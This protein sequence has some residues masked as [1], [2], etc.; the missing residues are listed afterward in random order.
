MER[1]SNLLDF[2]HLENKMELVFESKQF[3][4]RVLPLLMLVS[5]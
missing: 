2:M 3:S 4:V 1:L 5:V